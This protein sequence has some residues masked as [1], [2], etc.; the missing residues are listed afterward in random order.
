MRDMRHPGRNFALA[1][2][3]FSLSS[4]PSIASSVT[5]FVPPSQGAAGS[6]I[7]I[8]INVRDCQKLGALQFELVFDP[9]ILEPRIVEGGALAAESQL[10][11]NVISPGRMRIVMNT[12]ASGSIS[13]TGTLLNAGFLVQGEAGQVSE[14]QLTEVRAWDNTAPEAVPYPMLVTLESP[15]SFTVTGGLSSYLVIGIIV[16]ALA[17]LGMVIALVVRGKREGKSGAKVA[18]VLSPA[19]HPGACRQCGAPVGAEARFCPRCGTP[20]R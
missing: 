19:A 9:L 10:D 4:A 20:A 7:Q 13:G 14:L 3:L 8:S 6:E 17:L 18:P 12:S 5:L 16:A 11:F 2:L 1:W 15:A